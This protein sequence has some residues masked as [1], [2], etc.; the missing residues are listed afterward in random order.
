MA[1]EN[2]TFMR[3][4]IRW[5]R[6]RGKD[7]QEILLEK[8]EYWSREEGRRLVK[9]CWLVIRDQIVFCAERRGISPERF[10]EELF[11]REN[12]DDVMSFLEFGFD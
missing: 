7:Q 4:L 8:L 2:R 6:K 11:T 3:G 10:V 12:A 5:S 9:S 1:L